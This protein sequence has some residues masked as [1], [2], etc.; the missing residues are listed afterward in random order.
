MAGVFREIPESLRWLTVSRHYDKAEQ[1]LEWINGVNGTQ[2]PANFDI[3]QIEE[4]VRVPLNISTLS[5][6]GQRYK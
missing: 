5:V 6:H 3:R 4:I 1:V 2:L